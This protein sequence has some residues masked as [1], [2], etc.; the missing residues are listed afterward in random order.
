MWGALLGPALG[1]G[2][3]G[4]LSAWGQAGANRQNRDMV[5]EQQRFQERMSNTAHQREVSDLR[6]AGLNPILSAGGGGASSPSGSTPN[7]RSVSEGV[8][9]SAPAAVRMMA[10]IAK[11]KAD[12]SVSKATTENLKAARSGIEA[13]SISSQA[14]SFSAS[15][16][17]KAEQ[18][19][20]TK[21][22]ELDAFL[23][24]IGL[25]ASNTGFRMSTVGGRR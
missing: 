20:P 19:A 13:N 12:T 5:R 9:A 17:W 16:R 3:G 22:G 6:A 18:K 2:I 10:D 4:G 25:G 7:I 1:A 24:R 11:I 14:A 15:N 23:S 21:W 8:S